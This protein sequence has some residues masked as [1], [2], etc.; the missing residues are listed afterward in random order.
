[1]HEHI[2]VISFYSNL[3]DFVHGQLYGQAD[4]IIRLSRCI[5]TL[6]EMQ[7]N[8]DDGLRTAKP[9]SDHHTKPKM[10]EDIKLVVMEL[11]SQRVFENQVGRQHSSFRRFKPLL[12]E[13]KRDKLVA[14]INR[15]TKHILHDQ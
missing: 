11:V 1:M 2:M 9:L 14:W 3:K 12:H 7:E 8:F 10:A 6:M 5:G 13:I 15:T 4:S